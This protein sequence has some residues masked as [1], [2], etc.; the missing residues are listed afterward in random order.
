MIRFRLTTSSGVPTYL[1]IVQQ[2]KQAVSLGILQ[3]GDQLPTVKDVVGDLAINPNTV[4]R[5]YRELDHDGV[6]E[7]RRGVGTFVAADVISLSPA[8]VRELRPALERWVARARGAGLQDE[9]LHALFDHVVHP[10]ALRQIA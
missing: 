7:G 5:A 9:D 2:V 8:D 1:Q 10:P 6:T 4:L 3:P